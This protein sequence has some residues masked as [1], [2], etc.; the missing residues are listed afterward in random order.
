MPTFHLCIVP[1][2][3]NLHFLIENTLFFRNDLPL[4]EDSYKI[5]TNT[6]SLTENDFLC[7]VNVFYDRLVT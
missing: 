4:N 7:L 5:T 2:Q 3:I 6:I 1:M